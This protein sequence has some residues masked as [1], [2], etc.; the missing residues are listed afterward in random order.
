MN[1]YVVEGKVWYR[2]SE[3][4]FSKQTIC[5]Y[6]NNNKTKYDAGNIKIF[7]GVDFNND[8]KI[9]NAG[10]RFVDK[11]FLINIISDSTKLSKNEKISL[12]D[13]I[14]L[15][16][17]TI[18]KTR[19]EIELIEELEQFLKPFNITGEKQYNILNY[20]I[21]FYIPS[22]DIAIEYDE[23]GHS[24]Y[25]YEQHEG[26]QKEIEEVLGCRFIRICDDKSNAENLGIIA[27]E[28]FNF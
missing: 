1:K 7:K 12:L 27:K 14:G 6:I 21:D 22:M 23:N 16:C 26:R 13:G 9:N 5:N 2:V 11:H 4:P 18:I 15:K 8:I 24:G 25:T 20:R 10:E 17:E 28:L 3:L 19:K